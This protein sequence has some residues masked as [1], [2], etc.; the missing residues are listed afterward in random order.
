MNAPIINEGGRKMTDNEDQ[1]NSK[2]PSET[3]DP[4]RRKFIKN[5]GLVVGGLAGGSLL[6]G[7]LTKQFTTD[8]M[9]TDE[10]STAAYTE[11]RMFFKRYEDF[12]V[13]EQATERIYPEDDNGP[14]AI[15]LGVPY[16]IDKQMAGSWGINGTDYRHGPFEG[17][18]QGA[19][20]PT[21]QSSL[22]RRE[23][24]LAGIRKMNEIS[25]K[26][27]NVS[28]DEAGAEEQQEILQ[29]FEASKVDMKGVD[30]GSF[31]TLLRSLTLEGTYSDP[32]YGG[33]R[34]MAGWKMMEFPGAVPSY[35]DI[36]EEADFVTKDPI[37][38][39]SYQQKS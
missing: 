23:I 6:G 13:L 15:E 30:S 19:A 28:F 18:V 2:D 34:N 39:A 9:P 25:H 29:D 16:F 31:F 12:V 11:A 3:H 24:I 38:L 14:G 17:P 22:T 21:D 36:I 20:P 5:S 27:Y 33:N 37:S 32:L 26:E 10:K 7:L 8:T 35:A 1:K 4:D